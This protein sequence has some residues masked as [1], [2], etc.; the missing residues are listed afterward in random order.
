MGHKKRLVVSLMVLAV[1][2]LLA[3]GSSTENGLDLSPIP[4]SIK[5]TDDKSSSDTKKEQ[6]V[7]QNSTQSDSGKVSQ[8]Q[9]QSQPTQGD[10]SWPNGDK[11]HGQLVN[12]LPEGNGTFRA[13]SVASD[14][15]MEVYT[16]DWKAGK[17]DGYG[18][19]ILGTDGS[20]YEGNFKN[21]LPS[22][23][24]RLDDP[25]DKTL[26]NTVGNWT[27]S[28]KNGSWLATSDKG[29]QFGPWVPGE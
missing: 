23:Q 5:N 19:M 10:Y 7:D 8:K 13:W 17:M 4:F 16:G 2:I 9:S 24:G 27:T 26:S 20:Y 18:K 3:A 6:T 14:Y 21:N 1:F 11:Y 25:M 12:G 28:K 29:Q 15:W 22:G